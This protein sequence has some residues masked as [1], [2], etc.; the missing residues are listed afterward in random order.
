MMTIILSTVL[1]RMMMTPEKGMVMRMLQ[2]GIK[3]VIR[4]IQ[5]L[6]SGHTGTI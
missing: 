6:T 4:G 3:E 2:G 5:M 1:A